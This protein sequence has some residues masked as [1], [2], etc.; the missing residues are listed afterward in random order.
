[1]QIDAA[2]LVPEIRTRDDL[3]LTLLQ[4]GGIGLGE[5]KGKGRADQEASS[6][7]EMDL[8]T[9]FF[10]SGLDG[11]EDMFSQMRDRAAAFMKV[12]TKGKGASVITCS[13]SP[14]SLT[15]HFRLVI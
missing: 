2:G 1:M 9:K 13:F 11:G 12:K 10:E 8:D 4:P 14:S 15:D 3:D 5:G 7:L 6:F